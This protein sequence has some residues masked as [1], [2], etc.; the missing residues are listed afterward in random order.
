MGA[1]ALHVAKIVRRR[2]PAHALPEDVNGYFAEMGRIVVDLGT[3]PKPL[4]FPVTRRKRPNS[5][6]MTTRWATSIV[7]SSRS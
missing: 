3:T 5:V 7:T 1:L 6:M 2:H 4:C